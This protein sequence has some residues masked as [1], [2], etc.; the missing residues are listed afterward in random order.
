MLED[1]R[2][3]DATPTDEERAGLNSNPLAV[4]LRLAVIASVALAI[5]LT[6]T[7]AID[8]VQKSA[9]TASAGDR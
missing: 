6:A 3:H 1:L 2:N 5:G 8:P 4:L 9:T 7:V